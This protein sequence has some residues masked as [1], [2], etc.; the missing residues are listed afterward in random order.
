MIDVLAFGILSHTS[1]RTQKPV[2]LCGIVIKYGPIRV[3]EGVLV[4]QSR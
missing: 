2:S 1:F 4:E 3:S